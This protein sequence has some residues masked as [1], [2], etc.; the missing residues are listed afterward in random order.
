MS[1]YLSLD[2]FV[3]TLYF[4]SFFGI[5]SQ[6]NKYFPNF[7]K[8]Q[9]VNFITRIQSIISTLITL[10][11]SYYYISRQISDMTYYYFLIFLKGYL[12]HDS[13]IQLL[14]YKYFKKD[15][16]FSIIHHIVLFLT[17]NEGSQY[18]IKSVGLL[19][20]YTNIHLYYGWYLIQQKQQN[21]IQFKINAVLLLITYFI[22]RVLMFTNIFFIS[23]YYG[24]KYHPIMVAIIC[25]LNYYWFKLLADKAYLLVKNKSNQNEATKET[26]TIENLKENQIENLKSK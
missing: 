3:S 10:V 14:Y 24:E 1:S 17:V 11:G 25:L 2:I 23:I 5:F 6:M 8:Y 16:V 15:I 21:T 9:Q 18:N 19:S 12:I 26:N 20:E 13:V 22:F 7:T 4:T